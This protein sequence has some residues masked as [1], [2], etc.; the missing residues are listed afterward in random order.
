MIS[1]AE[2]KAEAIV[3]HSPQLLRKES[4]NGSARSASPAKAVS[5]PAK[6]KPSGRR[7]AIAQKRKGVIGT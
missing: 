1:K 4:E 2:R 7:P 6:A 3:A 5:A